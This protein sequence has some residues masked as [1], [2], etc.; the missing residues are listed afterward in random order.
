MDNRKSVAAEFAASIRPRPEVV[1]LDAYSFSVTD[2]GA[3]KLY[4]CKERG[5]FTDTVVIPPEHALLL[6]RDLLEIFG[7]RPE[8]DP[9]LRAARCCFTCQR[10]A[11]NLCDLDGKCKL[12]KWTVSQTDDCD[13]WVSDDA[14]TLA[15]KAEEKAA[16]EEI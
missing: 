6:A 3:C 13:D 12:H 9:G 14:Q 2:D 7:P 8:L 4:V 5:I 11:P 10:F 15:E 16:K 1:R